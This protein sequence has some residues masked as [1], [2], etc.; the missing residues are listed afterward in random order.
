L[1]QVAVVRDQEGVTRSA[2]I[3]STQL[4]ASGRYT[5][6]QNDKSFR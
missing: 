3:D 2:V 5:I 6:R 4:M 1:S